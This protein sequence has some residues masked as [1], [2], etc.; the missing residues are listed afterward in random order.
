LTCYSSVE[1]E[2]ILEAEIINNSSLHPGPQE[3]AW[4]KKDHRFGDAEL[5]SVTFVKSGILRKDG[6]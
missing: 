4:E 3:I 2:D 6:K 1:P 5:A